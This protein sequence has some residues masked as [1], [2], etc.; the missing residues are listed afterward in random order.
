MNF[1]QKIKLNSNTESVFL[2]KNF[3]FSI[4]V[5]T[6]RIHSLQELHEGH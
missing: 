2:Q 6:P 1:L 4:V 5:Q 3:N